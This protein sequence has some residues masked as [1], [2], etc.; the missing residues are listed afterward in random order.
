M[1]A[2]RLVRKLLEAPRERMA[3]WT[4]VLREGLGRSRQIPDKGALLIGPRIGYG[5]WRKGRN[6]GQLPVFW[7]EELSGSIY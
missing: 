2:E 7:L 5:G 1:E 6:P 4:Q 3:A